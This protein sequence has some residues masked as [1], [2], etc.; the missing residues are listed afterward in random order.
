MQE[1]EN[2][3]GGESENVSQE[4]R[5][6]STTQEAPNN[7][8]QLTASRLRGA[9]AASAMIEGLVEIRLRWRC[10]ACGGPRIEGRSPTRVRPEVVGIGA[11]WP[12]HQPG[13]PHHHPGEDDP[14]HYALDF[15][16]LATL[17]TLPLRL[18]PVML[19]QV[20]PPGAVS[21]ETVRTLPAPDT[22]QL[23]LL[24]A[25]FDEFT[26]YGSPE[27]RDQEFADLRREDEAPEEGGN[28][29]PQ[30]LREELEARRRLDL[31]EETR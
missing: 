13:E 19:V 30:Q 6:A 31:P 4:R 20:E 14:R 23:A 5:H 12:G 27:A 18:D 7:W 10:E 11:M 24:T 28:I 9:P 26:Y 1:A 29:T 16:P 15:V 17:R 25:L 8:L 21:L 3:R 22:M 2:R